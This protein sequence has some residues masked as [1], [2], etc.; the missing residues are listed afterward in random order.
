MTW[1]KDQEEKMRDEELLYSDGVLH[2]ASE[3]DTFYEQ[4]QD[5]IPAEEADDS[6]AY[7]EEEKYAEESA[8]EEYPEEDSEED[9]ASGKTK[10][11]G[12]R[13]IRKIAAGVGIGILCLT[14]AG[15]LVGGIYAG[16]QIA[17]APN[18]N[19]VNIAPDAYL[20][21]IEDSN[22]EKTHSL[23]SAESN[24]IYVPLNA[25]PEYLQKAF[26][27]IED[28]RFYT[29][30][31][32]DLKGIARAAVKGI[33]SGGKFTEGASTITQQLLKNN[34]FEGWMS[35]QGFE[36]RL[37]RKIQEQYLALKVE[38]KYSKDWILENYMNT[39]NLGGGT[40]GV[41]TASRY[42]FGKDVSEL[43]LAESALL[44]GITKN[45]SGYNPKEHPEKSLE[46]QHLVLQAME[47]Q[48]YISEEEHE[49]AKAE[50]VLSHLVYDQ[51][52]SSNALSW[53]EDALLISLVGD[54]MTQ[55]GMSEEEAWDLIYTGGLT[56]YSTQ[57]SALQAICE[58]AVNA[59]EYVRDTEQISVVVT[60]VDTGAVAAIVGGRGEKT[61]S[62]V[63]NR[64]T[65]SICQPGS[66]VKIIGEYA[67]AMDNG[68]TT[69][70]SVWEDEP[71]TYSDGT[72]LHNANGMY[73]GKTTIREAISSSCNVIALKTMQATG[74]ARTA[75]YLKRF[76]ITTL[77]EED[78]GEPLAIGGTYN[79]VTNLELTGAYNAI[80]AKG[81]YVRPY[82][83]TRVVDHQ[84]Q[85]ILE[86]TGEK[87]KA[88]NEDTAS[89][90]TLGMEEVVRYGT[91][92]SANVD[93]LMLAGK[94]GTTNDFRDAWFVGFSSAYTCGIWGGYDDHSVQTDTGH[95]KE[96]WRAIMSQT[97]A[98]SSKD[99]MAPLVDTESLVC[100]TIC[101][102]CGRLAVSG[103]C[104]QT[105]QG[106]MMAEEYYVPGTE[107]VGR[108]DCHEK[109]TLCQESGMR[110]SVYCPQTSRY[111]SVFLKNAV[112]GTS[113]E[114][115]AAEWL[116]MD[117]C[118]VHTSLWD[119]LIKKNNNKNNK[120]PDSSEE[121]KKPG[122]DEETDSGDDQENNG[123]ENGSQNGSDSEPEEEEHQGDSNHSQNE[124][125]GF[126]S[127]WWDLIEGW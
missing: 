13:R 119:R 69:L 87:T 115:Y 49:R 50:D 102:K 40:R 122:T 64:A 35:E 6:A 112:S 79:G 9:T 100:R 32:V 127:F 46:R 74:I 109:V 90:L 30:H 18:V 91:G 101:I 99:P 53:F 96:I 84:G 41:Q 75:E 116:S 61:A 44:A 11:T 8:E 12:G 78:Y 71:Y 5:A 82:F 65:N 85:V 7:T 36:S 55:K 63:Y 73:G 37:R 124:N 29:H 21:V 57:N 106:N 70:G 89:L 126:G 54:L 117:T 98:L 17:G 76:G 111:E 97:P 45:P 20:S 113:D 47:D 48:G 27:A 123:Q 25:T 81:Q 56:I 83:Y 22:G 14:V 2:D 4:Q 33:S 59:P 118:S 51:S 114:G 38:R 3:E 103:L 105:V 10:N 19:S 28:A 72:V 39:I 88:V 93:G 68:F 66:T 24:R 58:N 108:C 16:I 15:V 92:S 107:P 62:L 26:V 77:T 43:F 31:G 94:S 60:E 34:V 120:K 121:D 125:D 104:D 1:D 80:A 110:C 95:V 52:Q 23:Y 86:N 42:Y 67:A